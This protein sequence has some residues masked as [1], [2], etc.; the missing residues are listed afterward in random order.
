MCG[1]VAL[2]AGRYQRNNLGC[3]VLRNWTGQAG[4]YQTAD[5]GILKYDGPSYVPDTVVMKIGINDLAD[6]V[7]PSQVRDD[8]GLMIDQLRGSNPDVRIHLC[9]VLHSNRVNHQLV[10][11]LNAL[12]PELVALKNR[13]SGRSPVWLIEL[14]NGFDPK[15]MTYDKTHP[16]AAGEKH[17]GERIAAGLGIIGER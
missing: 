9:Q 17:V 6:G 14:N 10:D 15:K 11:Q 5:S 3:G 2:P 4:A 7:M 1:R 8:L 13:A 16:N 12:L